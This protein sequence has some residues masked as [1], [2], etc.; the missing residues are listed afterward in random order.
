MQVQIL[1][2]RYTQC[3]VT[4]LHEDYQVASVAEPAASYI[5]MH[6]KTGEVWKK[7]CTCI[8]NKNENTAYINEGQKKYSSSPIYIYEI[9]NVLYN[10]SFNSSV[11]FVF[12]VLL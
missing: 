5:K 3:F 12:K 10:I 9:Y 2:G 6:I 8:L 4:W 1:P 11:V 7:I